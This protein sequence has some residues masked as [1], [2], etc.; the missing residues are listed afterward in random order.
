VSGSQLPSIAVVIPVLDEEA[1]L[2]PALLSLLNQTHPA[3]RLI[4]VDGRSRDRSAEIAREFGAE[5]LVAETVGRGNQTAAGVAVS[6][7]DV[8]VVGHADM[9]F[10]TDAMERVRRHVRD[11]PTCPGGA[12]GHRFASGRWA[13]RLVEWFDRR[14]ALRGHSYGDQA[15]FFRRELLTRAGGF[16]AQPILEDVEL[17]ARLRT[18]GTPAYLDCPVTVSPRR[19]ERLGVIR[20]LWQNWRFRQAYR[21][22]GVAATRALFDRYYPPRKE[23]R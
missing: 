3:D 8:V 18:L 15:Q 12:L 4:V 13:F 17:A 21:R 22:G 10:P 19:F 5:V 16:P 7:E 14:R 9:L 11:N 2:P 20:T 1:V 6:T 23:A